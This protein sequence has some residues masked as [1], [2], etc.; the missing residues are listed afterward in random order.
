MIKEVLV[1]GVGSLQQP[2]I[3]RVVS[4]EILLKFVKLRDRRQAEIQRIGLSEKGTRPL[5]C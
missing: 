3:I 4:E 2:T 5:I 1:V